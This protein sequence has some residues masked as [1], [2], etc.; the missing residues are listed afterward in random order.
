MLQ[1]QEGCCSLVKADSGLFK[2]R[3]NGNRGPLLLKFWQK[4]VAKSHRNR[5][6]MMTARLRQECCCFGIL[7]HEEKPC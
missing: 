5:R 3:C 2:G 1:G 7:N 4:M 6:V